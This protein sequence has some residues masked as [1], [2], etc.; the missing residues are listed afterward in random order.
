MNPLEGF[1]VVGNVGDV[2]R[3][4]WIKASVLGNELLITYMENEIVALE[5]N[6]K[7]DN[8]V[9]AALPPEFHPESSDLLDPFLSMPDVEWGRI[10]RYPVVIDGDNILVGTYPLE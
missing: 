4:G 2:D 3:S 7:N 6:R 8:S 9:N 5:M 1:V 10:R